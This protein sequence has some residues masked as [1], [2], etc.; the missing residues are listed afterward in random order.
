MCV[1]VCVCVFFFFKRRGIMNILPRGCNAKNISN[2][3]NIKINYPIILEI[4]K[5]ANNAEENNFFSEKKHIFFY[6]HLFKI[7]LNIE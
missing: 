6:V 4:N 5:L 7:V 2:K 1:C 3:G